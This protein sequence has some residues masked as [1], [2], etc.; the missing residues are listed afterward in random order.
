MSDDAPFWTLLRSEVGWLHRQL[1]RL[2]VGEGDL[3]DVAQ[4]VL[5]AMHRRWADYD[6]TRPLR[7][8][9][10]GF[11]LRCAADHRKKTG[12][13]PTSVPLDDHAAVAD[14]K[15]PSEQLEDHARRALLIRA[16]DQL[17]LGKRAILTLVDLEEMTV[18]EAVTVLEIP[19]N[20]G[21]SRLRAARAELADAVRALS[22]EQS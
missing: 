10:F 22:K 4:E 18:P 20:T 13:R 6:R 11:A 5:I 9:A 14:A 3:D 8:W 19:L 7:A 16:L 17:D 15:E 1:R 12:R 2:G 21:Y